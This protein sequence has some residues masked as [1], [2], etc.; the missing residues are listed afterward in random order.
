MPASTPIYSL[1][2]P[3]ANDPLPV[4]PTDMQKLALAVEDTFEIVGGL[5]KI[6][7]TATGH[8]N[9]T[10]NSRGNGTPS[11]GVTSFTV[12][13]VFSDRFNA[14]RIRWQGGTSAGAVVR[15]QY[16]GITSGYYGGIIF[17]RPNSG[18]AQ[19]TTMDNNNSLHN[20]IQWLNVV[21]TNIVLDVYSPFQSGV[22]TSVFSTRVE[23]T[24]TAG[25]LNGRYMGFVS[26]TAS[27][28]SFTLSLTS[29]ITTGGTVSIYG[30]NI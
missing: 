12:N 8:T 11:T 28:S 24:T 4:M 18:S 13:N 15:L 14:Y 6:V 1:P 20:E 2:Y 21:S 22:N 7:P 29:A 23:P 25:G 3:L 27:V 16:V 5:K 17:N 26:S 19:T 9:I 10:F 30:Y